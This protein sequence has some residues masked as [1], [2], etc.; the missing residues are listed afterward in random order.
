MKPTDKRLKNPQRVRIQFDQMNADGDRV[1]EACCL[2]SQI[3]STS[4][5]VTEPLKSTQFHLHTRVLHI[6]YVFS[7]RGHCQLGNE[8]HELSPGMIHFVYP[9]EPHSFHADRKRPYRKFT[10]KLLVSK[11]MPQVFPR[12]MEAGAQRKVL[13]S[14]CRRLSRS[15]LAA[16][17]GGIRS[18]IQERVALLE[19]FSVLFERFAR[20]RKRASF[21]EPPAATRAFSRLLS[22][23]NRPP[24]DSPGLDVLAGQVHMSRRQFTRTFRTIT[25]MSL[26]QFVLKA[27]MTYAEKRL[28]AGDVSVNRVAH[29]CGYANSQNFIRAYRKVF[30]KTPGHRTTIEIRG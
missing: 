30:R 19:L 20:V 5:T 16:L 8:L 28:V 15:H 17:A 22:R 7:G 3:H 25:G 24:F 26:H 27:R 13:E 21:Q 4:L 6:T 2:H 29:E 11:R 18:R 10:L 12:M 9:G 14:A 1:F 23:L